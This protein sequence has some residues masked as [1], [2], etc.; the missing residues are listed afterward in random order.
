[1]ISD[2]RAEN[3]ADLRALLARHDV[4]IYRVAA[5]LNAHPSTLSLWLHGKKPLTP[6]LAARIAAAI[7]DEARSA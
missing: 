4:K 1:M 3:D 6:D 2:E 7:A 5:R